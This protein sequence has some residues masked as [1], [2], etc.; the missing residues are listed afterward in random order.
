MSKSKKQTRRPYGHEFKQG[1]VDLVVKQGYSFRAAAEAVGVDATS[2]RSWHRKLAPEPE[3][4][5]EDA[6]VEELTAEENKRLR[7]QLKRAELE[8]EILKKSHGVFCE[9]VAVKYAWINE[10]RDSFPVAVMCDVL[11]VSPSGYY[12]SLDRPPSH[13]AERHDRIKQTVEQVHA[14][15]HGIY[16]SHKIAEEL[17]KRDD[18]E[19]ACR[20]TVAAA[21]RELGLKAGFPR[22]SSRPPPKPIR[23]SSRPRTSST[24]TS[25]PTRPI[26]NG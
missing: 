26:A 7:K 21:M 2:L 18:L 22:P 19:S 10:H 8:R 1:A 20:N 16:G 14:E 5:G 11:N 15:S 23:P 3:P 4:C 9:G 6:T 17:Q 13:R 12:D 25:R 24:A